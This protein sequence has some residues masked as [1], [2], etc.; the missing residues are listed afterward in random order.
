MP[1]FDYVIQN[2][3]YSKS[4]YLEFINLAIKLL[5]KSKGKFYIISPSTWLIQLRPNSLYCQDGC[6]NIKNQ[7]NKHITDIIIENYNNEFQIGLSV[8]F[9]IIKG[10]LSKH[11]D[12]IN[13]L[14]CGELSYE[15][16]IYNC[17]L[18][19]K[20]DIINSIFQKIKIKTGKNTLSK[21]IY[22]QSSKIN[23]N[24][25]FVAISKNM[26][27]GCGDPRFS[28]E[29]F[30]DGLYRCY[31]YHCFNDKEPISKTP[32]KLL[33]TG[34]TYQNPKYKN[35]LAINIYGT[36]QE[37]ENFKYFVFNTK[38]CK[39]LN[40]CIIQDMS[41]NSIEKYIPWMVDK[42]YK[43]IEIYELFNFDN[44]E[45]KLIENTIKKYNR[46]SN[47]FQRYLKGNKC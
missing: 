46:N 6:L 40:I 17:N 5:E 22:K 9:S 8:P 14:C 47:W 24:T 45:I 1:K 29:W 16:S 21:H 18:V 20:R 27:G 38:L 28:D 37:L 4:F 2:P 35:D 10:N 13:F 32:H 43:D 33:C 31:Y 12:K 7:L 34:Y 36:Q 23:E 19:G 3:P 15:D 26:R 30:V 39:F 25:R 41:T 42:I 44:D 11:I